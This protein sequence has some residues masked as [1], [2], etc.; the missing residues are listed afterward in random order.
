MSLTDPS[1]F[2]TTETGAKNLDYCRFCYEKGKFTDPDITM[3]AMADK[4]VATM[5]KKKKKVGSPESAKEM[6]MSL[7]PQLKR[8]KKTE[9]KH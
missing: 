8:W 5:L 4:I 2:G 6:T 3:E 7:L 9:T 1:H